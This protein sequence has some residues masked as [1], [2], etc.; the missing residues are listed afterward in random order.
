MSLRKK[1]AMNRRAQALYLARSKD[2]QPF[3][4]VA[5]H[6][7]WRKR[8]AVYSPAPMSR[9][10]LSRTSPSYTLSLARCSWITGIGNH[11]CLVCLERKKKASGSHFHNIGIRSF[12]M[13]HD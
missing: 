8:D 13:E 12:C 3:D 5:K 2:G 10:L 11:L 1:T 7:H 4:A 6:A 9:V